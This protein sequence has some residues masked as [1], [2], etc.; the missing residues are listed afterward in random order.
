[1]ARRPGSPRSPGGVR[2]CACP[3][4]PVCRRSMAAPGRPDAGRSTTPAADGRC[5]RAAADLVKAS[6][7][8][9]DGALSTG[10]PDRRGL[11]VLQGVISTRPQGSYHGCHGLPR[12]GTGRSHP[13]LQDRPGQAGSC[14]ST[15]YESTLGRRAIEPHCPYHEHLAHEAINAAVRIT[16]AGMA[17]SAQM[18]LHL[19]PAL[20]QFGRRFSPAGQTP[21]IWH[22][23][24]VKSPNGAGGSPREPLQEPPSELGIGKG[25]DA[26]NSWDPR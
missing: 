23:I 15:R 25:R 2:L 7:S 9:I 26:I 17:A 18:A 8:S 5:G 16:A 10:V 20:S 22:V 3:L 19:K 13:D 21:Q 14:T 6:S 4:T 24:C 11:D 12:S 1:V